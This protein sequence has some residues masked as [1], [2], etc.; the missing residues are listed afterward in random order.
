[1]N[2]LLLQLA[3]LLPIQSPPE[4]V[5]TE[6]SLR[7]L[8]R[9]SVAVTDVLGG[10]GPVRSCPLLAASYDRV[11]RG[12]RAVRRK[13][14]PGGEDEVWVA[15]LEP[16]QFRALL[17]VALATGVADLPLES[18]PNCIDV[19]RRG[20]QILLDYG[21]VHWANGAGQGC[22]VQESE[23]VPTEDDR[24]RFD[25]VVALLEQAFDALPMRCG[26]TW[27]LYRDPYLADALA[28]KTH[29]TVMQQVLHD[30]MRNAIDLERAAFGEGKAWFPWRGRQFDRFSSGVD[31][32]VDPSGNVRRAVSAT[33]PA[34]FVR[35]GM[36]T[37]EVLAR[38]GE[39]DERRSLP[40]GSCVWIYPMP[41][42]AGPSHLTLQ[43]RMR[44]RPPV[45]LRFEDGRLAEP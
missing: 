25:E 9:S 36:S 43:Y 26:Q 22:V 8:E 13:E 4:A 14:C 37:E 18:P 12:F 6:A 33:S 3:A 45:R 11:E 38:L 19:Y 17:D 15:E 5:E 21:P 1:M 2:V 31:Y 28:L 23:V 30:P 41:G 16:Q 42:P 35:T 34:R 10:I 7:L 29:R 39:P 20:R 44:Q 40:D 24:R 27:E 32:V